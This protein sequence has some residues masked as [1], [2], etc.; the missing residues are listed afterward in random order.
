VAEEAPEAIP[1]AQLPT[2]PITAGGFRIILKDAKISAKKVIIKVEK[3]A[4][5]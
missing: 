2:M 1:V 3:K 4:E 5:K